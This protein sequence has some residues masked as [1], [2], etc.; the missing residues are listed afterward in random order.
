MQNDIQY[1]VIQHDVI[2]QDDIYH[3]D[4]QHNDTQH[5]GL[6]CDTLSIMTFSQYNDIQ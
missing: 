6:I 2:Q 5:K 3:D 1:D 4:I